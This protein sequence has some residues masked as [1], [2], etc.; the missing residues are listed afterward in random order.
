[1]VRT[2]YTAV[3]QLVGKDNV[4]SSNTVTQ[5][6]GKDNVDSSNTTSW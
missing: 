3:T 4:H 1:L 2:M 6:V 5:M